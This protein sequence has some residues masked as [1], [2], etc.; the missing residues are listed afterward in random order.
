MSQPDRES[1][2]RRFTA[3]LDEALVRED[4]PPGIPAELL[5]GAMAPPEGDLYAVQAALTALTQEVKLQ[6]RSFKQLSETVA[7][8]TDLAPSLEQ[9]IGEARLQARREVL[10]VLLD[11]RDRL[12]RGEETA[13]TAAA[14][15]ATPRHWWQRG[16]SPR[17]G[18]VV[19]ALRE[20]YALT[21][22]RLD[23]ALA[24]YGVNEIPCGGR[25][26]DSSLMHATGIEETEAVAEGTVVAV[27]RRG[28]EWNGEI[29]RPAEVRVARRPE[30]LQ[31]Q[32]NG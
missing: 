4:A 29:Y 9:A 32:T 24:T 1:I 10:D 12:L 20:G 15:M 31:E 13:R 3:W 2:L 18:E 16:E 22:A 28:Y 11:L 5:D 25:P 21:L 27:F 14:A 30:N 6:G 19:A 23:E 7:P 26:F 17:A 8:L